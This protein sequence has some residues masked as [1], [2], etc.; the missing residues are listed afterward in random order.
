MAR[1]KGLKTGLLGRSKNRPAAAGFVAIHDR[2]AMVHAL[3][4]LGRHRREGVGR[5]MMR[6]AAFW[7]A[8]HGAT[9]MSVICTQ[10]NSA[11]NALYSSMSYTLVGQYHYRRK[12]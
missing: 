3:E 9:H 2:I 6:Q 5:N 11:A 4:V 1:A 12:G 7:A 8:D 10:A